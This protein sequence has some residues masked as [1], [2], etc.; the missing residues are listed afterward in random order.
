M[1]R[2]KA[3]ECCSSTTSCSGVDPSQGRE[4][5]AGDRRHGS[6]GEAAAVAG[7]SY[8][9]AYDAAWLPR[10]DYLSDSGQ[11]WSR[12]FDKVCR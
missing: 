7:S 6:N 10:G 11:V 9:L 3:G 2:N 5:A 4:L 12:D 8:G 1:C